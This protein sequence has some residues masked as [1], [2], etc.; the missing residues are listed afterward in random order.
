MLS[1]QKIYRLKHDRNP[2]CIKTHENKRRIEQSSPKFNKRIHA[3][4]M[5][6]RYITQYVVQQILIRIYDNN[7][8]DVKKVCAK[9]ISVL[10]VK[11]KSKQTAMT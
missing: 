11:L 8:I 1:S 10:K 4:I 5:S 7:G 6:K 2:K 9:V 3:L